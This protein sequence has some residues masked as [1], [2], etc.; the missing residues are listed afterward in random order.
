MKT[1]SIIASVIAAA[2]LS[3]GATF[4]V[5]NLAD[6]DP[7]I[8]PPVLGSLRQVVAAAAVIPNEFHTFQFDPDLEGT[9]QLQERIFINVSGEIL[10]PGASLVNIRP[11]D[12]QSGIL[13]GFG[14]DPLN[15][16]F[17]KIK[18]LGFNEA[19]SEVPGE[20][21]K[22]VISVNN[23]TFVL[24]DC[25]FEN[26]RYQSHEAMIAMHDVTAMS[27]VRNCSFVGN[28][29]QSCIQNIGDSLPS[30][31]TVINSTFHRNRVDRMLLDIRSNAIDLIHNTF[32]ENQ[33][34]NTFFHE[35]ACQI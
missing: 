4:T 22:H 16:G 2:S 34:A 15:A 12:N 5:T 11:A 6:Y 19:L 23:S 1:P 26:N 7:D 10:G 3:H 33:T 8:D 25:V 14:S 13:I 24:E 29:A 27:V 9:L 21:L 31:L 18:G 28:H 35:K 20:T 30:T 17:F 32:V